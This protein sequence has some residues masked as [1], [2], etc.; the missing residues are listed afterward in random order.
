M[1]PDLVLYRF[2]DA[3]GGLLY[4]GKSMQVW[5]RMTEHRRRSAFYPEVAHVTF[6]RGFATA[7]EL[8]AAEAVAIR[9]ECPRFNAIRMTGPRRA[10]SQAVDDAVSAG[11]ARL[12]E[13]YGFG[14]NGDLLP[15][16]FVTPEQLA[17]RQAVGMLS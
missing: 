2:F 12:R 10:K 9:T 17:A 13:K 14:D 7:D 1:N 16:K 4:V 6:Q 15:A 3:D 5:Q 11:A 8:G